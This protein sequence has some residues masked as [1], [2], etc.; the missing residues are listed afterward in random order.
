M[1]EIEFGA[2]LTVESTSYAKL[3]GVSQFCGNAQTWE[4]GLC[5]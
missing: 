4:T 1:C 2:W 5:R 3:P